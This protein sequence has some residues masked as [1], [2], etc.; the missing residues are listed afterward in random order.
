MINSAFNLKPFCLF[1]DELC[2]SRYI[3]EGFRCRKLRELTNLKTIKVRRSRLN[4]SG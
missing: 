4:T 1:S 2:A 3:E